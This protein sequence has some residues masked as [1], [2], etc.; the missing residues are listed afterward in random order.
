MLFDGSSASEAALRSAASRAVSE[1][2]LLSVWLPGETEAS[3]DQL[4]ARCTAIVGNAVHAEYRQLPDQG[5]D[6][7]VRTAAASKPRVLVLP[8]SEPATTRLLV[9]GLLER[10][11]CSLLVVRALDAD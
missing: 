4:K 11:D 7:L 3:R 5:I 1:N 8:M 2:L 6:T 10:T 9:T